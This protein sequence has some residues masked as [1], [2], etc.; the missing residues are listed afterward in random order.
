MICSSPRTDRDAL[1][2]GTV[3]V[4]YWLSYQKYQELYGDGRVAVESL[5]LILYVQPARFPLHNHA[6]IIFF[7]QLIACEA[8][9][10]K[11]HA[12]T[13]HGYA[14]LLRQD[15]QWQIECRVPGYARIRPPWWR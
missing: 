1:I 12:V 8:C 15:S 9:H 5:G 13:A 10:S 4:H 11:P 14:E 3:L 2:A 7:T 6:R